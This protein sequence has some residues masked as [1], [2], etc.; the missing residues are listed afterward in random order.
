MTKQEFLTELRHALEGQLPAQDI[1]ENIHYYDA[2]FRDSGKPEKEVCEELG[3]PRLIARSLI[4]SFVASKG[5]M[6]DF[7]TKQA[8]DEYSRDH[9]NNAYHREDSQEVH[10]GSGWIDKIFRYIMIVSVAIIAGALLIGVLKF[11]IRVVILGVVV[12]LLARLIRD[13]MHGT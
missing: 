13:W 5:P 1:E 4:D 9:Q 2:Y 6:A 7:Y 10:G 11:A 3:D 12:L 8:R